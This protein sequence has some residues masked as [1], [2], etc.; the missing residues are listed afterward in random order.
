MTYSPFEPSTYDDEEQLKRYY[1]NPDD[2][3]YKGPN[4]EE[5]RPGP[6]GKVAST[7]A[8]TKP[9]AEPKA[10]EPNILEKAG[11]FIEENKKTIGRVGSTLA[12]T[13]PVVGRPIAAG[14]EAATADTDAEAEAA[15]LG[16]VGL[17]LG[18]VD[19]GMDAI[20][21][22]PGGA[23]IDDTWDEMTRFKN[24]AT[25]AARDMASVI[26]PSVAAS[27]VAGPAAGR[28][29]TAINGGKVAAG[30]ASVT[31]GALADT[32][33]AYLS[34]YS[35]RDEGLARSTDEFLESIGRPM[36]L[37]IPQA[38]QVMDDD[39]PEV[40]RNK[41]MLEAGGLS[42]IGD[43][44]GYL[45]KAG[46]PIMNWFEP[47]D[48]A[49][50]AF[51]EIKVRENPDPDTV[52]RSME[53]EEEI[54]QITDELA[55]TTDPSDIALL[56]TKQDAL[57]EENAALFQSYFN[58][59]RTS[60]TVDPLASAIEEGQASRGW[61]TDEIGAK[62]LQ[63]D[64]QRV[65]FDADVQ[66]PLAP[67][68]ARPT[69]AI[70]RANVARNA[71]DIAATR[72]GTSTGIP[73]PLISK[74]MLKD[75]M[76]LDE[77]SRAIVSRLVDDLNESGDFAANVDGFKYTKAQMN[78]DALDLFTEIV[79][80]KDVDELR[81]A[82][83][84]KKYVRQVSEQFSLE[85]LDDASMPDVGKAIKYLSKEFL[86]EDVAAMS[87]RV[88]AT[89]GKEVEAHLDAMR[90]FKGQANEDAVQDII[91][92]KLALLSEEYGTA[93][94][95]AG[96][97]LRN[98]KWWQSTPDA[99]EVAQQ[100]STFAKRNHEEAQ[101]FSTD[102][103]RFKEE[104][105]AMAANLMMAY[106]MSNGD[107]NT[108]AKLNA[109]AKTQINPM[110]AV[111]G[112]KFGSTSFNE[113]LQGV[114]YNN[115]LSG[116]S[117]GRAMVG[118][119]SSIALKPIDYMIGAGVRGVM[120]GNFN[121]V[122]K[123]M[124]AFGVEFDVMGRALNDGWQTF[125]KASNDPESMMQMLRKDYSF[126]ASKNTDEILDRMALEYK[127]NG[128]VGN[129]F[130]ARWNKA[131]R[132]LSMSKFMRYGTNAMLGIDRATNIMMATMVSKFNAW[133]EA[134]TVGQKMDP[135]KL[136]AAQE[137][138]YAKVFDP[139]TDLIKDSWTKQQAADIALNE[140]TGV[141]DFLSKATTKL[142]ALKAFM[143]FP[144]TGINQ[145]RKALS[146]TPFGAIPNSTR[147]AKAL[148]AT[149]PEQIDEVMVLHGISPDD[150][151]KLRILDN[152]K[153]E[154]TG[155]LV[156]GSMT[157]LGAAQYALSGNI[158]GNY[159]KDKARKNY[160]ISNGWRPKTI[161]LGG[162]WVSYAG[163]QM[164]DPILAMVG[165]MAEYSSDMSSPFK[166]D[167]IEKI[168]WT[169]SQSFG[170]ASP[171]TGLEPLIALTQGDESAMQR[172]MNNYSR[173]AIPLSSAQ[174]VL[175]KGIDSSLKE[176]YDDLQGYISS[177]IPIVNTT[178]P[179]KFDWWT[180]Q[181]IQEIDNPM[182]RML[183]AINPIPM[184]QAEEPWRIW[185]NQSGID[186]SQM[187]L[188]DTTGTHKY[189]SAERSELSKLIG[190][191]QI[192]KEVEKMMKNQ[193]YNDQLD[194][195]RAEMSTG[196]TFDELQPET[197]DLPVVKRLTNLVKDA[198]AVAE[199]QLLQRYP[200]TQKKI[201]GKQM[202]DKKMQAG[203]PSGAFKQA[204]KTQ[205]QLKQLE[206]FR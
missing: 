94:Y 181:P 82:L 67:E 118:G 33:I 112:S 133:D 32:S 55:S 177:R 16:K 44:I 100:F 72:S 78:D 164:L 109:W 57:I 129:L 161:K 71:A 89:T 180:G 96:W 204:E 128:D 26:V 60:A 105:P 160:L 63:Q 175:A 197:R 156:V 6:D 169:L 17:E 92:D 30:I 165:D 158:R 52:F 11:K 47:K 80:A 117:A 3:T 66:S 189:S 139:K 171:L 37:K 51:K 148:M 159:P 132:Y 62:K 135:E 13:V 59:G 162:V 25:R 103:R 102:L 107:V 73:A 191:Q 4:V 150:P 167:M 124:Y 190:E 134:Y 192:Y 54:A 184:S 195:V 14:I 119:V 127:R 81:A 24:P 194:I 178:V 143:M 188:T 174:A 153:T 116:L 39:S 19:F 76:E 120:K 114:I 145:A 38:I 15:I 74:P 22:I 8:P 69:Q 168:G 155:R 85:L 157:A 185:V 196:K 23:S 121:D 193:K 130:F 88:M 144:N 61:Q 138:H 187:M 115:V 182:L 12:Q 35:E 186:L 123:G 36:G 41:L 18:L 101:Q 151:D 45:F 172:L 142:P 48:D 87:G 79:S 46:K 183:N 149:S 58:T 31:A 106:D 104:N 147:N 111:V 42:V 113:N 206:S 137:K 70:P 43:A 91:I 98:L 21:N 28:A 200:A 170:S 29:V 90:I 166:E 146:Y 93:K 10:E 201:K 83:V 154:Y 122:R 9:E 5:G 40:R 203:D 84:P 64:P 179:K 163:I 75:G 50:K 199:Q 110:T 205:Q 68:S 131:N 198:K 2:G 176:T 140:T 95:T 34:D 27:F 20:G 56:Q 86:G 136:L 1:E 173:M 65:T 97:S 108:I 125:K 53:L 202:V 152:M 7:E 77:P 126:Q 49:A 141:G 99:S